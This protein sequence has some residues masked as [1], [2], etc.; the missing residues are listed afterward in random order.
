MNVTFV[1][2]T[3]FKFDTQIARVKGGKKKFRKEKEKVNFMYH[4]SK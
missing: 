4:K 3:F 1:T 2:C